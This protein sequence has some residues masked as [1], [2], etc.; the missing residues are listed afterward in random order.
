MHEVEIMDPIFG[1]VIVTFDGRVLEFFRPGMGSVLR[2]H[3]RQLARVDQSGPD[4]R[5]NYK[6]D[7]QPF[8]RGGFTL[9]VPGEAWPQ[10]AAFIA[11]IGTP[12]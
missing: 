8:E 7:F 1:H 12:Q 3:V 5:G 10:V 11:T 2:L 4:R 9:T 6:A